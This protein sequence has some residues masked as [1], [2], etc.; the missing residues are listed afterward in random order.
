V[1]VSK[2]GVTLGFSFIRRSVFV[3]L[4]MLALVGLSGC[5]ARGTVQDN[6]SA[7][8]KFVYVSASSTEDCQAEM[9]DLT[10]NDVQMI[11]DDRRLTMS[12]LSFG[13]VPAHQCIGVAKDTAAITPMPFTPAPIKHE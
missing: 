7:H 5:A 2:R 6:P 11:S 12:I 4:I 10:Q 1:I 3:A 9:N 8:Q 13:I